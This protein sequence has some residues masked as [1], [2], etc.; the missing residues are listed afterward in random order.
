MVSGFE[1]TIALNM[2]FDQFFGLRQ[3]QNAMSG[4]L[5]TIAMNAGEEYGK[6]G[7]LYTAIEL[8]AKSGI[9]EYFP[10][11]SIE[12]YLNLPKEMTVWLLEISERR[13]S[14]KAQTEQDLINRM[15]QTAGVP[16]R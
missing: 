8:Y 10:G 7:P 12:A 3:Y 13:R 4:P 16:N 11:L 15:N 14:E 6:S 1:A 5:A 9:S 2:L